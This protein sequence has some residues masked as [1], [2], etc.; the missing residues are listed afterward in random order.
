LTAYTLDTNVVIG[1]LFRRADAERFFDELITADTLV[2]APLLLAECTSVIREVFD[3][4]LREDTGSERLSIVL[5]LPVRII[6]SKLQYV[7]A[8]ELARQF[9]RRNA[10]DTQHLAVAEAERATLVSFDRGHLH[11][12]R[13]LGVA[14]YF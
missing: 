4:R 9:R 12:A 2:A 1:W 8:M 5:A 13:Q 14:S 10:Y 3:R 6:E 11:A 7:R